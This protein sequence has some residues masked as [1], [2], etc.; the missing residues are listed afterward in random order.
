MSES[1]RISFSVSFAIARLKIDVR[2]ADRSGARR[3]HRSL[4]SFVAVGRGK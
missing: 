3:S 4:R 2:R 1:W